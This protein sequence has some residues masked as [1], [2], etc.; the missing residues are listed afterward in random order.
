MQELELLNDK[1]DILLKKYTA[2]QAENNRLKET[3]GQQLKSIETLNANLASLEESMT[4]NRIGDN[5]GD[6]NE[7]NAMRK[8]LD[9]VIGEIDKILTTLND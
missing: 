6:D 4:A 2:L 3:V 1:L 8:Q 7:K 5:L 9:N